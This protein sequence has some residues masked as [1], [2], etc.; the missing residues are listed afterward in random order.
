M[1][2]GKG[3]VPGACEEWDAQQSPCCT[4][5][6]DVIRGGKGMRKTA[7]VHLVLR[8]GVQAVQLHV[9]EVQLL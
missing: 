9:V 1:G 6:G 8:V 7:A 4:W 3:A 2:G 5:F